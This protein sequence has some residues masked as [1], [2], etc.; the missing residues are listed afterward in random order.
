VIT[1]IDPASYT[2]VP[3][4][5]GGGVSVT[6]ADAR[7]EG[8]AAGDWSGVIWQL[9]RTEIVTSAPFS[10]LSGF[11]RLQTV[12]AG[13]GLYLDTPKSAIDLSRPLTVARY[14]GGTPI[15]SRLTRGPVSVVN[16]IARRNRVTC[17]MTVLRTGE[18][19]TTGAGFCIVYAPDGQ[20][21]LKVS[22][23]PLELAPD[24]ALRLD[25]SQQIRC[26]DGVVLLCHIAYVASRPAE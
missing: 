25:G 2:R 4:K 12:I 21:M 26:Q 14:D 24:H 18:S 5:N 22:G 7:L 6:I 10:D 13:E 20:T 8:A 11:E 3:W 19:E 16:L 17:D 1:L 23:E 9:G 15:V